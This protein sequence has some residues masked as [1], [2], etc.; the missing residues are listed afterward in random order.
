M[1][2]EDKYWENEKTFNVGEK[3]QARNYSNPA[4]KWDYGTIVKQNGLLHYIVQING[5]LHNKHVDQLL[6]FKGEIP[7]EKGYQQ[8]PEIPQTYSELP[9]T[10]ILSTTGNVAVECPTEQKASETVQSSDSEMKSPI[11]RRSSRVRK[12]PDRLGI[13]ST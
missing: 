4:K 2:V 10:E 13:S 1:N 7:G 5:S 12:K 8:I 6:P 3:V 9:E 11:L